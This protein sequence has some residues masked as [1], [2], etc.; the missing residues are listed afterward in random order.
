MVLIQY[1]LDARSSSACFVLV[2]FSTRFSRWILSFPKCYNNWLMFT[3]SHYYM[4]WS[5]LQR[6][7]LWHFTLLHVVI[8]AVGYMWWTID[9]PFI[10]RD[11][12]FDILVWR[13]PA[14]C[15]L[16]FV[17]VSSGIMYWNVIY[18]TNALSM[19]LSWGNQLYIIIMKNNCA[20]LQFQCHMSQ[21][22]CQSPLRII[23]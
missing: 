6:I 8:L 10:H 14:P 5:S 22:R 3:L 19:P 7:W 18:N 4:W 2:D 20:I 23:S 17:T 12:S 16:A 9:L 21:Y 13:T 15:S 1:A 11:C